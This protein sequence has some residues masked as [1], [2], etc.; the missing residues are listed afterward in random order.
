M[1]AKTERLAA[2]FLIIDLINYDVILTKT[3]FYGKYSPYTMGCGYHGWR[4]TQPISRV[5]MR[6]VWDRIRNTGYSMVGG[7]CG[8]VWI[9]WWGCGSYYGGGGVV[10]MVGVGVDTMVCV[11][12]VWI[13]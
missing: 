13:L 4:H 10:S 9:L 1:L 2:Q 8:W 6:L 11:R 5:Y 3:K 7:V 12:V